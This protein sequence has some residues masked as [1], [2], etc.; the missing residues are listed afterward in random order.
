M[1]FRMKKIIWLLS[2]ILLTGCGDSTSQSKVSIPTQIPTKVTIPVPNADQFLVIKEFQNITVL[3]NILYSSL[4]PE[5]T[6]RCASHNINEVCE[7]PENSLSLVFTD[8]VFQRLEEHNI[9]SEV[10][11]EYY[12]SI[13]LPHTLSKISFS[14]Q[15]NN[16]P[17]Q[18]RLTIIPLDST[19]HITH[20]QWSDDNTKFF[21]SMVP[22]SAKE[23]GELEI[24]N[25]LFY[26]KT[27]NHKE[28]IR[29][30]TTMVGSTE[31]VDYNAY[32][33]FDYHIEKQLDNN[34]LTINTNFI[35]ETPLNNESVIRKALHSIQYTDEGILDALNY[36]E[37]LN[38]GN[39]EFHNRLIKQVDLYGEELYKESCSN[40][41][42][43]CSLE[44]FNNTIIEFS[45]KEG[46]LTDGKYFL[47]P[48]EYQVSTMTIDELLS[49][50]VGEFVI[51]KHGNIGILH[52]EQYR[53]DLNK[54]QI[55]HV[56]FMY[57]EK[58][59]P[60]FQVISPEN[61]P[62]LELKL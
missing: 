30:I 16:H 38:S 7:I 37:H 17:F 43:E 6:Q 60:Y 22:N 47:L 20:L 24:S 12:D 19:Q 15:D 27:P 49:K 48:K 57:E 51:F 46:N 45:I 5:V 40:I 39:Q 14:Q 35:H 2:L 41:S 8:E 23:K 18:Y 56:T 54:L 34:A 28:E 50:Q 31:D 25:T 9:S 62:L 4:L 3:F 36:T 29:L 55:V 42:T 26:Q 21:I 61:R 1:E 53:D 11:L 58:S 32:Y 10:L 44:D 13:E 59:T 33:Y 52:D